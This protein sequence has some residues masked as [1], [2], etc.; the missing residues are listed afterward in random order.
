[1]NLHLNRPLKLR[2]IAFETL[3][4]TPIEL[5][6]TRL[7]DLVADVHPTET[8]VSETKSQLREP[9]VL[10]FGFRISDF[11][12]S[13][14]LFLFFGMSGVKYNAITRL[15]RRLQSHNHPVA[16]DASHFAEVN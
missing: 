11:I 13:S 15:E 12:H 6:I 5:R 4:Q 2:L 1:M 16:K 9:G 10:S 3:T 14:S 7:P 8:D